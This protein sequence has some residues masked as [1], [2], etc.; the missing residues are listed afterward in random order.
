MSLSLS[1]SNLN[2][3]YGARVTTTRDFPQRDGELPR[4]ISISTGAVTRIDALR[5][6][7]LTGASLKC[8]L[9]VMFILSF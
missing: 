4:T 7:H 2:V 5:C 9:H 8:F 3:R 1:I 6:F